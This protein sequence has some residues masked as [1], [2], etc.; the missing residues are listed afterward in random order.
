MKKTITNVLKKNKIPREN[1]KEVKESY[2]ENY[3][4]LMKKWKI[5][6]TWKK[7]LSSCLEYSKQS[8]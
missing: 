4:T 6:Q 5:I 7:V 2:Y 8:I 1:L 3:K